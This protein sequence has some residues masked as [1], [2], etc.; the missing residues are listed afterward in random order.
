MVTFG[1]EA[2]T[3]DIAKAMVIEE[4]DFAKFGFD[5]L[6]VD[7]DYDVMVCGGGNELDD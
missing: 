3:P 2:D 7:Y 1:V 6:M 4:T 5:V